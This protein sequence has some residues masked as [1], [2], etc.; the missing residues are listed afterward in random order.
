MTKEKNMVKITFCLFVLPIII[1][2]LFGAP[3]YAMDNSQGEGNYYGGGYGSSS[4]LQ[5]SQGAATYDYGGGNAASQG[6]QSGGQ[7]RSFGNSNGG[8]N[9]GY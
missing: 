6:G 3:A 8:G 1:A 2:L 4:G 5:N 7:D 9:S